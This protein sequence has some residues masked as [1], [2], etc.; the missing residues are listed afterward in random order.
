MPLFDEEVTNIL[1]IQAHHD[2]T[3][4]AA[5]GTVAKL[6]RA[7]K[8]VTYVTV[9][10]G[11]FGTIDTTIPAWKFIKTRKEEQNRAAK[12]LGV[13][14][15]IYLDYGDQT[16]ESSLELRG[17]LIDVIR[18]TKPDIVMTHDPW[19]P[20]EGNRDHRHT[21]LMAVE[22][23]G[24][25]HHPLEN[26]EKEVAP[27]LVQEMC[28]FRPSAPDTWIDIT[29]TINLKLKAICQHVSQYGDAIA[30]IIKKK[31][32]EDGKVIKKPYAEAFKALKTDFPYIWKG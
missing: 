19:R 10:D 20:Y 14:R 30:E 24:M 17:R 16:L 13:V 27:H 1:S 21:G 12:I 11:R 18:E 6:T 9:T 29:D 15:V 3:D 32:A 22:A 7:G 25:A 2:D 31:N 5:G 8:K 23:A 26:P 28:L 4:I